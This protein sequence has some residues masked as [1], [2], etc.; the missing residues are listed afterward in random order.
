[1]AYT[2]KILV[3]VALLFGAGCFLG[4]VCGWV[5][6]DYDLLFDP[7]MD[8]LYLGLRFLGALAAVAVAAG[9]VAMLVR[10]FSACALAFA[11]SAVG[12][13][14]IWDFTAISGI[15]AV[16]YFLGGLLYCWGVTGEVKGRLRFSVWHIL[17][18][19]ALLL[20]VLIAVGCAALYAGYSDQVEKEGFAIPS[21]VIDNIVETAVGEVDGGLTPEQRALAEAQ[22][23]DDVENIADLVESRLEPSENYIPVALAAVVFLPLTTV[24]LLFSWV[25]ILVLAA[26]FVPLASLGVVR[27]KIEPVE[28]T[29]L[30][31]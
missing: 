2:I 26:I 6:A 31:L 14:A 8:T 27:K 13:L 3:F 29:R 1:M 28:V 30:R 22:L 25:P 15:M 12:M 16:I 7:S 20:V 10:P 4:L 19:Q 17:R 24:A 18:S 11:L 5:E 23:R 21:A 9:L